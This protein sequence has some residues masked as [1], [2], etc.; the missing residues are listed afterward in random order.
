MEKDKDAKIQFKAFE[1][2][3]QRDNIS[4]NK[5]NKSIKSKSSVSKFKDKS[6]KEPANFSSNNNQCTKS[7]ANLEVPVRRM[8]LE[9]STVNIGAKKAEPEIN[10]EDN[11]NE[12]NEKELFNCLIKYAKKGD[13]VAFIQSNEM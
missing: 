4:Q 12:Y 13:R 1:I 7:K 9:S 8:N 5:A 11:I 10:T 3:K 2:G 6:I